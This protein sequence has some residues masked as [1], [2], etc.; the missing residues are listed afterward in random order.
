MRAELEARKWTSWSCH[1]A[2]GGFICLGAAL[3]MDHGWSLVLSIGAGLLW[4]LAYWWLSH[5]RD[6]DRPSVV[7]WF[8][9][10]LGAWAGWAWLLLMAAARR[11]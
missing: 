5:H 3:C 9:W 8:A 2:W 1:L 7:D 11:G 6:E 4:E 10:G